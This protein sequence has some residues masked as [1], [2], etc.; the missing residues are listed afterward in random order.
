MKQWG[1]L[2]WKSLTLVILTAFLKQHEGYFRT[3]LVILNL[4]EMMRTTPE[5][6]PPTLNFQREGVW[7]P[8]YDLTCTRP[9][10]LRIFS[11]I[12]SRAWEPLPPVPRPYHYATAALKF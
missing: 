9:N 7:A 5:L 3:D 1:I 6:A 12:G 2:Y 4:G 8:T 10:I 11:G